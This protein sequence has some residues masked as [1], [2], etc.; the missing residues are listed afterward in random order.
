VHVE[1]QRRQSVLPVDDEKPAARLV[2][3]ARALVATHRSE[4][5]TL[6]GEQQDAA[7]DGRLADRGLVEVLDRPHLR[8]GELALK[9]LL[10][11]L[12][13]L[14]ERADFIVRRRGLGS[15]LLP[16]PVEAA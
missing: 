2:Q 12:D 15:D 8:S 13:L 5:E 10:A 4:G 14:D 11:A 7:R 16:F 6:A 3:A 1:L 9:R